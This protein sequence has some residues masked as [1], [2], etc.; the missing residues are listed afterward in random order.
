MAKLAFFP[1]IH[2]YRIFLYLFNFIQNILS[3]RSLL[4]ILCPLIISTFIIST[5]LIISTFIISTFLI[6]ST[7]HRIIQ[8]P[9][10]FVSFVSRKNT[11]IYIHFF[12]QPILYQNA[13][14]KSSI[15]I[16][17]FRFMKAI[18]FQRIYLRHNLALNQSST[19]F[20][21]LSTTVTWVLLE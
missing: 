16:F 19:I 18:N 15:K 11:N 21:I 3:Y 6:I 2:Q 14:F 12:I 8:V 4:S 5:F 9:V 1:A 7:V 13:D 17:I 10:P 20:I